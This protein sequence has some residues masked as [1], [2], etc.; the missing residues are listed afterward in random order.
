MH[1]VS[2]H[3]YRHIW[4]ITYP[5]IDSQHPC[6]YPIRVSASSLL[7]LKSSINLLAALVEE[8]LFYL[9]AT[10][11]RLATA[12]R[13]EFVI[14]MF[15]E[16]IEHVSSFQVSVQAGRMQMLNYNVN[17]LGILWRLVLIM[18][19]GISAINITELESD[20]PMKILI[21]TRGAAGTPWSLKWLRW[22]C[23]KYR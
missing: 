13:G 19:E 1:S 5:C 10:S 18:C 15:V 14:R 23:D 2:L 22:W 17:R 12:A 8:C 4:V 20:L 21:L 16:T 11:L 3:T 6:F 7:T 9:H